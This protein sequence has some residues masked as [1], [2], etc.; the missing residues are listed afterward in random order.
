MKSIPKYLFDPVSGINR[1]G[2]DIA[3][4]C[5]EIEAKLY[6]DAGRNDAANALRTVASG[7]KKIGK[8]TATPAVAFDWPSQT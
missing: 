4:K 2:I 1:Y 5:L 7:L 3:R 8:G 6:K